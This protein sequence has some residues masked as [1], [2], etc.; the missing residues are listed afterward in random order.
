VSNLNLV[1]GLL[2]AAMSAHQPRALGDPQPEKAAV[3]PP[4]NKAAINPNDPAEREYRRLLEMDDAAQDEVDKWIKE[5]KAFTEKGAGLPEAMLNAKIEQ[6]FSE[7]RRAYERFLQLH[8]K[9]ARSR[10]AYGSFLNDIREEDEAV[11]QWEKARELD[12]TNPAAWN[13]LANHYGHRSPVKKAF[14]YYDKAIELDPTEPVYLQNLATTIYLFRHDAQ[15]HYGITQDEVFARALDLYR[16]ALKLDPKNF[17]LA[18]DLAQTYYG[19]KPL[20]VEEALEAWEYALQVANDDIEREGVYLHMARVELNSGQFDAARRHINLVTNTMYDV[21]KGRVTRNL[22]QKEAQ[23][24]NADSSGTVDS[25]GRDKRD[26]AAE[27]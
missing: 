4:R 5:A 2:A 9:H 11:V 8:P 7:I 24:K 19:I 25:G 14:A 17:I 12:P 16:K 20:R 23:A 21:L 22:Q 1:I 10:L 27:R 6:R 26:A 13:N 15:E 3:A 18:Q